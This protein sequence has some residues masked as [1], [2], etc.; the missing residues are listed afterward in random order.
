MKMLRFAILFAVLLACADDGPKPPDD[1]VSEELM[2]EVLR[3]FHLSQS[4][5]ELKG[6]SA[7]TLDLV[8]NRSFNNIL[9]EKGID[10]D[11]FEA[12]FDYYLT[13]PEEFTLLYERVVAE[14]D[15]INPE[16]AL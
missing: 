5:H 4:Y 13:H 14:I 6:L 9:E 3:D 16:E 7:D 11:K 2:V 12:T 10:R 15:S 8:M 1:P